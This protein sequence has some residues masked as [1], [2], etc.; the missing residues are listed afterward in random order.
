[1]G[2]RAKE[3]GRLERRR[4]LVLLSL[5]RLTKTRELALRRRLLLERVGEGERLA[6]AVVEVTRRSVGGLSISKE[7][8]GEEKGRTW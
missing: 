6:P 5:A 8:E 7:G 1:M 2:G 3:E 4:V